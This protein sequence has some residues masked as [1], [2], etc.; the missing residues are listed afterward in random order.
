MKRLCWDCDRYSGWCNNS[1]LSAVFPKNGA[2]WWWDRCDT[3]WLGVSVF[4]ATCHHQRQDP[5]HH[6]GL[7]QHVHCSAWKEQQWNVS[8]RPVTYF[9]LEIISLS[10]LCSAL[11]AASLHKRCLINKVTAI[12][13]IELIRLCIAEVLL[14]QA[15]FLNIGCIHFSVDWALWY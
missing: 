15:E 11:W 9:F 14:A 2:G 8:T 10:C 7:R 13:V 1:F 12:T 4:S 5:H 6:T 3:V